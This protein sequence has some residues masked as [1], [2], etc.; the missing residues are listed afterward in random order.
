MTPS[1]QQW[2]ELIQQCRTSGLSD[3][4]WCLQNGVSLSTFYYHIKALRKKACEIP[5]TSNT[6]EQHQEVVPL[7]FTNEPPTNISAASPVPAVRMSLN[8][9]LIDIMNQ[10]DESVIRHTIRALQLLC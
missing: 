6:M 1:D 9:I 3:R 7:D 5:V 4:Q 8:G 10:A 2:F